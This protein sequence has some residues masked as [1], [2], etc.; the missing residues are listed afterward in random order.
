MPGPLLTPL[1]LACCSVSPAADAD[2]DFVGCA[3]RMRGVLQHRT[4]SVT[5][6]LENVSDP[7][8]VAAC[9]RSADA[10]GVQ[11]VH[12]VNSV[13]AS[14][15]FDSAAASGADKWLTVQHHHSARA[16]L[17]QLAQQGYA[18]LASDLGEGSA[19]IDD[20]LSDVQRREEA[21]AAPAR[22]ALIL[23]NERRGISRSVQRAA[24]H[25]YHIPMVGFAQ[26]LNIS[27]ACAVSLAVTTRA[28]ADGAGLP[29]ERQDALLARWLLRDVQGARLILEREGIEADAL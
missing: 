15:A 28:L 7:H 3:D 26:S 20:V 11:D 12:I 16:C 17:E 10:F 13:D 4:S 19:A 9:L 22:V 2:R 1:A 25:R 6:V 5:V 18:L 14:L 21:A 23:G 24:T 29:T 27:V 8:N